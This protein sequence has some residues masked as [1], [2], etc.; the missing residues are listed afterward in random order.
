MQ[1]VN[2][3]RLSPASGLRIL[4]VDD[5]ARVA[6]LLADLLGDL[7]HR[8]RAVADPGQARRVVAG[9]GFDIVF[10]DQFLGAVLGLDLMQDLAGMDPSLAFVIM[11]AN[12]STG[13]AV[14]ALQRGALDFLAKPFF[15]EDVKRSIS[16][17]IR[18]RDLEIQQRERMDA[19]ERSVREKTDAL[20]QVHFSV[21]LSLARAVEKKD[22]GTYGHSMRVSA[23]VERIAE[24]LLLPREERADLRAAALLHDIGKIGISDAILGK[25]G[26]LTPGEMAIVRRHPENGADIL[27]PLKHFANALPAILHH[28]EHYDGS[29][30]PGGLAAEGIPLAARI[31][32]VADAYDAVLSN[33][34]YRRAAAHSRAAEMLNQMAGSQFDPDIVRVFL[35]LQEDPQ[36]VPGEC[37]HEPLVCAQPHKAVRSEA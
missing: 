27:R 31:I 16:Y 1:S 23:S 32:A 10:L 3:S 7:G 15:E 26:P 34:P 21:L 6:E 24:R 25:P 9:G 5:E 29:G 33:R 18:K 35:E 8:A 13:L 12:S 36:S 14:E 22:L 20:I 30:Y 19:L 2:S 28:H 4:V 11:T 17:V 37:G